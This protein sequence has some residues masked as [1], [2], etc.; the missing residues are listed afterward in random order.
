MKNKWTYPERV[1]HMRFTKKNQQ[2]VLN[3]ID[4]PPQK[5]KSRKRFYGGLTAAVIVILLLGG[6]AFIPNIESVVAKIPYISQFIKE[7][8]QRMDQMESILDEI[9]LVVEENG[10]KIGD[11]QVQVEEK[12]AKVHLIGLSGKNKSVT[13]QINSQLEKAGFTSYDVKVVPYE[14]EEEIQTERSKEEIEQDMQNSKA[15]KTSLTERLK[16]QGYELMFPVSVRINNKEGIYMN[17]IVPESEKRLKQLKKIMKEE[18]KAYG[19]EYKLDVRQVQ[20]IA[21]EQEKRWQE[22]GAIGHIGRALMEAKDLHVTGYAYS[23]HPYPLQLKIKT[24]LESDNPKASQIAKKIHS[25]I[26]LFIQSNEETQ[27]IRDD[28]YNVIVLSK[29]KEEI[30]VE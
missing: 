16:A 5:K 27:T 11:L 3:E 19:D 14:E 23:F 17:V 1:D 20:K 13:D 25:E 22:T 10:M 21:R 15:L 7:E 26:D 2:N 28:R 6:T 12:E 4:S 29:D 8:E 9:N 30:K 18:A 24:S